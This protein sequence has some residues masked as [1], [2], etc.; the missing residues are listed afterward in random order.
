M[1]RNP[2]LRAISSKGR[3]TL[4]C[5]EKTHWVKFT[6]SGGKGALT[7]ETYDSASNAKR[8]VGDIEA[9]MADYLRSKGYVVTK[10]EEAGR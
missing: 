3:P 5:C 9:A 6:Y 4:P 8:A 7:S 10:A 2:T 1:P